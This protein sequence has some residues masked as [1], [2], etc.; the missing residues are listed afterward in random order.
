[1]RTIT[2]C[3]R[4]FKELLRDPLGYVFCLGFPI[5][6][7]V[8]FR[9]VS[10]FTYASIEAQVAE[11]IAN[12]TPSEIAN[13]IFAGVP[14]WMQLNNLVPGIMVFSYSFV[15]LYMALLVS[16]DKSG[17]FLTR[18]Y[19]SPMTDSDFV[20]GY[21]IPGFVI[22]IGQS[23]ICVVCGIVL[24]IATGTE[25]NFAGAALSVVYQIPTMLMFVALGI[26]FG[27]LLNNKSAPGV[28]SI[29][30]SGSG[31]LSG[32][33]MDV[34]SM[35][36]YETF[37]RVLPFYPAVC[38]GRIALNGAGEQY[39]KWYYNLAVVLAWTVAALILSVLV[40]RSKR[41]SDNK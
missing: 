12:G 38:I 24:G 5:V 40:F 39:G 16:N 26:L 15:M 14:A 19:I 23:A 11:Q 9:V 10:Y 8:V 3:K 13:Q 27:I 21:M 2:F 25:F 29:I 22:A 7:M 36:G 32:A 33:W 1:M 31:F 6:M 4:N 41:R 34:A 30:I 20:F 17:A 35:G 37:C 28:S 18:L